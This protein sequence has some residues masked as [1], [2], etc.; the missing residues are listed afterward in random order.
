[1]NFSNQ[2]YYWAHM[3]DECFDKEQ[4]LCEDIEGKNINRA[5]K[6]IKQNRPDLITKDINGRIMTR[7]RDVVTQ[8]R[9]DIPSARLPYEIDSNGQRKKIKL[10]NG[11][12]VDKGTCKYLPG[13]C[14]VYLNDIPKKTG[15]QAQKIKL[16]AR[17]SD[18]VNVIGLQFDKDFGNDDQGRDFNGM[19]FDELAYLAVKQSSVSFGLE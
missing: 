10:S 2:I 7:A 8:I 16:I 11:D 1:M 15:N 6:W 18:L 9:H 14:R 3:L 17:L 5:E 4:F 19:S 12:I 13:I